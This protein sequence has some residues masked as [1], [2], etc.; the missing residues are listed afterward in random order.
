MAGGRK[1][2]IFWLVGVFGYAVAVFQRQT[3]GVSGLDA[4][5]RFGLGAAG[6]SV[7]AMLQLL[8]YAGMQIP[9]GILVD[10][11]GSKRMLL[12]GALIMGLGQLVFA[13]S[14]GA[15]GA[16]AARVLVGCGDAM[17]FISVI[18]MINLSFPAHRNP[19][20]VQLTGL[21]G[22]IGGIAAAVPLIT[23]LHRYGW[24]PTFLGAA[25]LCA[26]ALIVVLV[27]LREGR[28][29]GAGEAR[30][31]RAAWAE[32]GTRLGMW[33]HAAT[34][35]SGAAFLLLWGYP[36]LVKEQGLSPQ[37]AGG[38]I[39]ALTVL[40][41]AYNPLFGWLAGRFPTRRSWMVLAIVASTTT[42]WT[43]VL[44]W[45]GPAPGW[46]LIAHMGVLAA[47]GP[48]SVIG[49]DYARTFNPAERIGVATGIVNGGGFLV[50]VT[51]LGLIGIG[52][53]VHGDF[54]LA[55]AAQYPIW[56]IAI[57]QLLRYRARAR[58]QAQAVSPDR[59]GVNGLVK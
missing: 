44:L 4:A 16:V 35:S 41:L 24:T 21:L 3:L 18:R 36:F 22:A 48:G 9:V 54:R 58:R 11:L 46:L 29:D 57:W 12:A 59:T 14:A 2:L 23:A 38:L 19:L 28:P 8:V 25:G 26:L 33:T 5:E 53:D 52:L 37:A 56:A 27:G 49:F 10:R 50:T 30:G 55:L 32:P 17:T 13:L 39:T 40:S 7:L 31:V 1:A 43:V 15:L 45:P 47:N 42:S 20:M 6:L 34:Q 51:L